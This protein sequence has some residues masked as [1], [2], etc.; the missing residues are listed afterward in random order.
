MKIRIRSR[1]EP[2]GFL[3]DLV[4]LTC[5]KASEADVGDVS[6][7]AYDRDEPLGTLCPECVSA[8]R[9][10]ILRYRIRDYATRLRL[11]ADLLQRLAEG[12]IRFG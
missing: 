1:P 10:G 6:Y 4:C 11:Q 3:P 9:K 8:A 2:Q 5:G 7:E 12:E